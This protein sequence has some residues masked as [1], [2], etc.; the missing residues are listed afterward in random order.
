MAV[1]GSNADQQMWD[2]LNI[3]YE[4]AYQHNPLKVECIKTAISLLNPGSRVLD[5]G[6]G[7]G[8]PTSQML[9]AAGMDVV[10]TDSAPNMVKLAHDRVEGTFTAADMCEFVPEGEFA[11]VF[12]IYSHLGL[13][14]AAFHAAAFK[15]A[16]T[17]K[18]GGMLVIGQSPTDTHVK[19]GDPHW[20]T[21]K[22]YVDDFN[23]PFWGEPFS[24][25]MMSREGQVGFLR[26]MGLD[27]VYDVAEWFQP[28]H[29]KCDAE[30]QQYVIARRPNDQPLSEP[31]PLPMKSS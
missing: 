19:K 5:V 25:L 8:I 30:Y 7:T 11:A 10:G 20:D 31:K 23:L 14:Y 13:R 29:P 3:D 18:P 9:A 22:S 2:D 12:I 17:L 15:F 21:T 16:K 24:T 28:N 26:S 6:C 27:V 4:K 1:E